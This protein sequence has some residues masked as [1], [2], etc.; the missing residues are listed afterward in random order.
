MIIVISSQSR[1][2]LDTKKMW[3]TLTRGSG[4][5]AWGFSLT[6]GAAGDMGQ[7][8]ANWRGIAAHK[9]DTGTWLKVS[10]LISSEF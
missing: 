6:A 7:H 2:E 3:P 8:A 4:D 9:G 10:Q 1:W 5:E